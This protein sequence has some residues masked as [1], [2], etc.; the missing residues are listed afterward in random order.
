MA[1]RHGRSRGAVDCHPLT[2]VSTHL[3]DQKARS[4]N[5]FI[6]G[7]AS[8]NLPPD[9]FVDKEISSR[10]WWRQAQV[11]TNHVWKRWL[12]EY[13]PNLLQ[14]RKW[15]ANARNL[16]KGHLM[17]T[18]DP[19]SPR[20][21]C[22]LGASHPTNNWRLGYRSCGRDKDQDGEFSVVSCK[23]RPTGRSCSTFWRGSV[24]PRSRDRTRGWRCSART[25][26]VC[27]NVETMLRSSL[28]LVV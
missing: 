23:D 3:S 13:I 18:A 24:L 21:I 25:K 8:P 12:K 22:P 5:H 20:G 19:G 11:V 9:I 1:D 14:R 15:T 2:H 6:L 17:L 4:P 10:R 16:E 28:I 26:N 7:R 27:C